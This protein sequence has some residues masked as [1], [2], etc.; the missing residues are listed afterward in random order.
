MCREEH[1]EEDR[2]D[3]CSDTS[4][5]WSP[6]SSQAGAGMDARNEPPSTH[7][8][9][10]DAM[11][12]PIGSGAGTARSDEASPNPS[13]SPS[14]QHREDE[15]AASTRGGT[16]GLASGSAS[17]PA[18]S[19]NRRGLFDRGS[20]GASSAGPRGSSTSRAASGGGAPADSAA[21]ASSRLGSPRGPSRATPRAPVP[22]LPAAGAAG[23]AGAAEPAPRPAWDDRTNPSGALN[24]RSLSYRDGDREGANRRTTEGEPLP[25]GRSRTPREERLAM[26]AAK[27][28][29]AE[30]KAEA[31][32]K[33]KAARIA[34][35]EAEAVQREVASAEWA[36]QAAAALRGEAEEAARVCRAKGISSGETA[37]AAAR[38]AVQAEA[39]AAIA[40]DSAV[41]A[42]AEVERE[43]SR[44]RQTARSEKAADKA[45]RALEVQLRNAERDRA[46]QRREALDHAEQFAR[47]L[48][49]RSIE[50]AT[51][52]GGMLPVPVPMD[53]EGK[54]GD[55]GEEDVWER[56]RRV[57]SDA[58]REA[59][60]LPPETL[61][62]D[63]V[64]D[65]EYD[66]PAPTG[67]GAGL[68]A[69][70]AKRAWETPSGFM[71]SGRAAPP[72]S[73]G[74]KPATALAGG[75]PNARS[76]E[77]GFV[78]SGRAAPP[79]PNAPMDLQD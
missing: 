49:D 45:L 65:D 4:S 73:P 6:L 3:D 47:Q 29:E 2:R 5:A 61:P 10:S 38:K 71:I 62:I 42:E 56:I 58:A 67:Q 9:L 8:D 15:G 76:W 79:V 20:P 60:Q 30:A 7:P 68:T 26:E 74:V 52:R 64:D 1:L 22:R 34:E 53:V 12:S 14:P 75:G 31:R 37:A 55:G 50:A 23:A 40:R 59:E 72:V 21:S 36:R 46:L 24:G 27:A 57:V 11:D 16:R 41:A 77:Q 78:I 63:D 44:A 18:A 33:A 25:S 32:A 13:E 70:E 66:A 28:A 69:P 39:A 19:S 17:V 51:P 54:N 48:R 43:Q 35:L